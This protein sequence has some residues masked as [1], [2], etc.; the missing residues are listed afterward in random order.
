MPFS[1]GKRSC[2]GKTFAE[3]A[4]R[5]TVA[6]MLEQFDFTFDDPDFMNYTP[7]MGIGQGPELK[8]FYHIK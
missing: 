6:M 1:L 7:A 3:V 2:F 4:G 5:T 8:C